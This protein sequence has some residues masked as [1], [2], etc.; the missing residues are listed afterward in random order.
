MGVYHGDFVLLSK[1]LG[2]KKKEIFVSFLLP[3][4]FIYLARSRNF[5]RIRMLFF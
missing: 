4:L 1:D 3:E 2:G 5:N